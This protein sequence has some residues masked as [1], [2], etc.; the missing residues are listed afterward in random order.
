MFVADEM[1]RTPEGYEQSTVEICLF[2]FKSTAL[3]QLKFCNFITKNSAHYFRLMSAVP[4]EWK[5]ERV[6]K[7]FSGHSD[8][9][10]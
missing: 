9:H 6:C 5:L 3:F 2:T 10:Y 8:A 1:K 4:L 7:T